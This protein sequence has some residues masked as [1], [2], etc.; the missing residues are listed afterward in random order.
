M[1]YLV[2]ALQ[3]ILSLSILVTLH[4]FGHF[5]P[6]K[7]FGMRVENFTCFLILGFLFTKFKEEKQNGGSDGCPW[8][9]M[10]KLPAWLMKVWIQSN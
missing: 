2:I 8:A 6:A 10:L 3:F 7:W 9:V 1:E 5:L 4:E